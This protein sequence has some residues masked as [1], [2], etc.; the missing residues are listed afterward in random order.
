MLWLSVLIFLTW[1][2]FWQAPGFDTDVDWRKH[3]LLIPLRLSVHL[4]LLAQR[5]NH[6]EAGSALLNGA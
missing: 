2:V 6:P 1:F 4:P 3:L 5:Q